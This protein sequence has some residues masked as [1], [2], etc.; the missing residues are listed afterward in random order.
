MT[1][2]DEFKLLIS[3][4][5]GV[6]EMDEYKLK[7]YVLQDI[8][9]YIN[10]FVSLNPIINYDYFKIAEDI[11]DKVGLKIKLQDSLLVLRKVNGPLELI[12]LIKKKI[13]ELK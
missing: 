8:E 5:Y 9:K 10:N 1:L 2:E 4:Y 6:N 13:E 3:G 12:L 7:Q 11:K